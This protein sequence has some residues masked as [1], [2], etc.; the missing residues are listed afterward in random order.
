M[1][2]AYHVKE[3]EELFIDI[4][5]GHRN[6]LSSGLSDCTSIDMICSSLAGPVRPRRPPAF[7]RIENKTR[8]GL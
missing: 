1:P 3:G 2:H 8:F 4:K 7:M 6:Q 5:H